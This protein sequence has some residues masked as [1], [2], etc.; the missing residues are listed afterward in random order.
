[1]AHAL[2]SPSSAHIWLTCTPS[3]RLAEQF[4]DRAGTA[5]AEGTLAHSMCELM[6]Q[7]KLNRI[8]TKDY[9]KKLKEIKTHELYQEEM[10]EYCDQYAVFVMEKYSEAQSRHSDAQI[11]LEEKLDMTMYVPEGFGTSDCTIISDGILEIIDFKYGK[12]VPV[13]AEGN[14]QMILYAL[15]ALRKFESLFE[16]KEVRWTIFQPRID[17]ISSDGMDVADLDYIGEQDI[18]ILAQRA[19]NGEGDYKPG[20]HCRFCKAAPLCK[21]LA[22]YNLEIARHEFKDPALLTDEDV[23]DILTR[24]DMFTKWINGVEEYAHKQ[25]LEGKKWPGYKLVE[26]RS[27]RA[28]SDET[29]VATT[30][31]AAGLKDDEIYN[32]KLQGITALEKHL[33]KS[34]FERLLGDL[35]IKPQGKPTLVP[36][37]DKR[38]EFATKVSAAE[39]FEN[40][41]ENE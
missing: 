34:D 18:K 13:N 30:L 2:L 24:S 8:L 22:D 3:A 6:V 27:N 35:V 19:W 37:S 9:N 25:A 21:A 32:K 15:G 1:M 10:L 16:I 11:F 33:G 20:E 12:G 7:K 14:D 31:S 5:A 40:V 28:Y 39:D 17:N 36:E 38:P 23:S 4:P 26:G 29:A 41:I